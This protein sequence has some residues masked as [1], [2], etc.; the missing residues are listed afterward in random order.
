MSSTPSHRNSVTLRISLLNPGL[1]LSEIVV[2]SEAAGSDTQ[3]N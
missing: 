3:A 2:S 1:A